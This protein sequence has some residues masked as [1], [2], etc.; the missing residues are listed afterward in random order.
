[1][2]RSRAGPAA[3]RYTSPPISQIPAA[4]VTAAGEAFGHVDA[5]VANHARGG[6]QSSEELTAAEMRTRDRFGGAG[7]RRAGPVP[8]G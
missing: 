4:L 8:A 3:R 5:V 1:V 2:W 6:R 7:G